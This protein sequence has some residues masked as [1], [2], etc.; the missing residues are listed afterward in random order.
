MKRSLSLVLALV[1]ILGSFSTVFA[2][3]TTTAVDTASKFLNQKEVLVGDAKGDLM[4]EDNL[5]RQDTAVL[6]SKLM[7]EHDVA[8]KFPTSDKAPTYKDI[9]DKFYLPVLAWAQA[10]ETFVGHTEANFGFG[11]NITAQEYSKVLL[12]ALGYKVAPNGDSDVKWA[13][14][15]AKAKEFGILNEV[16]VENS[17]EITRGEMAVMTFNALSVNM[18]GSKETLA[19]KLG[20]EM[21]AA[22]KLE[23]KVLDTKNLAEIV[24]ELS[25]AKLVKNKEALTN[26]A[27]YRLNDADVKVS[28][29]EVDGNDVI[30]TLVPYGKVED[31]TSFKSLIKGKKYN[32]TIRNIDNAINKEYKG[33]LAE[34]NEIPVVENIE[35]MGTHG[36]KVTTSE[37]IANLAER[38]FRLDSRTA[39]IVEQ[40]GREIILT[41]YHGKEFAKETVELTIDQLDDF[42][43]YR[44]VKTVKEMAI[45]TDEA[46]PTVKE[47]YRSGNKLVVEF[48]KDVYQD[49]I[50]AYESRREL[51]NV[52]FAER[53]VEF[54]AETAKK[55]NTNVV[56]Y[57]FS[58]DIPKA[59]EIQIEGVKNH[60]NKA[61][62]KETIVPSEYKDDYAPV[63]IKSTDKVELT[64][65]EDARIA[66]LLDNKTEAEKKAI[67]D[68]GQKVGTQEM[69]IVFDKDIEEFKNLKTSDIKVEDH[70][71]LYELD[72]TKKGEAKDVDVVVTAVK[73]DRIELSFEGI[74]LNNKGRD[75]D[76]ILEVKNFSDLNRNRMERDYLDFQVVRLGVTFDVTNI[77][78]NNTR[79]FNRDGAEIVLEFNDYVSKEEASNA[80]NY[81]LDGKLKVSEAI[82]E[83]DGKTV[84]LVVYD[85]TAT[86]L[87]N[88]YKVLEISPRVTLLDDSDVTVSNRFWDLKTRTAITAPAGTTGAAVTFMDGIVPLTTDELK[89]YEVLQNTSSS[90]MV[91]NMEYVGEI[92]DVATATLLDKDGK[93]VAMDRKVVSTGTAL[94][95][96][97]NVPVNKATTYTLRVEAKG[98]VYNL[99]IKVLGTSTDIFVGYDNEDI[100]VVAT[101]AGKDLLA[102]EKF[103]E[104]K[105]NIKLADGVV[106][107]VLVNKLQTTTIGQNK[108]QVIV[109]PESGVAKIHTVIINEVPAV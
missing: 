33:I 100:T 20:I 24:V 42:A 58:R 8:V 47:A 93:V 49:S 105:L 86:K 40:Y 65:T 107:K 43:N 99:P 69:T 21:P 19:D 72:I 51:G 38:N 22:E 30:L 67:L 78:I 92:N 96:S 90:A 10:N 34:D 109:T 94:Q 85:T 73:K 14:A 32:L 53:R 28:N 106:G 11:E 82:V 66:T 16:K 26:P 63:V 68:K 98:N 35:F 108:Y 29:V 44:S 71:T 48:D 13:D 23:A 77:K 101:S 102:G 27:N 62:D 89:G 41:P 54:Y 57:T 55:V 64:K 46:L 39:M 45:S 103:I 74:K 18:K 31:Q 76:Y 87:V 60:F 83:K 61:M 5:L 3:E 12:T 59:M 6:V 75:F 36:I 70:F 104:R 4:L 9:R 79:Y 52:S 2:A 7:G 56:E 84:S 1:M 15:L 81:Y 97:I 17:T 37:P 50:K 80:K 88:D 91:M 95:L 25:N